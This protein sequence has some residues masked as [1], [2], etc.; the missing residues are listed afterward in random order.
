[1]TKAPTK[2]AVKP[3]AKSAAKPAAKKPTGTESTIKA[4]FVRSFPETFRRAGFVFTREG[5][6][7]ALDLLS[8]EQLAAIEAEPMLHVEHCEIEADPQS[9]DAPLAGDGDAKQP[10][11]DAPP[12]D[13]S[14]GPATTNEDGQSNPVDGEGNA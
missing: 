9:G 8:K 14:T 4:I 5:H 7:I 13:S 1:M 3:A 6:G 11:N 2:T 10:A 12:A